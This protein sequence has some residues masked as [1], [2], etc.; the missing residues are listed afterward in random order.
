MGF[1]GSILAAEVPPKAGATLGMADATLLC[2][3]G[4][5][6]NGPSSEVIACVCT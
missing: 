4:L 6:L 3:S 5:N 2:A 1:V